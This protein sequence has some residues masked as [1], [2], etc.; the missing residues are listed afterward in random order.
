MSCI[1]RV[2][3]N[4]GQIYEIATF[5]EIDITIFNACLLNIDQ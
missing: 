2:K 5:N 1:V 3:S 4:V